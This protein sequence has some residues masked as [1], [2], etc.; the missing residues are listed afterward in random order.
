MR[1]T[2]K[3][4]GLAGLVVMLVGAGVGRKRRLIAELIRRGI[5]ERC[6]KEQCELMVPRTGSYNCY[7]VRWT[8]G[9]EELRDALK[10][11]VQAHDA[12]ATVAITPADLI[13]PTEQTP[14][15]ELQELLETA[16]K[17]LTRIKPEALL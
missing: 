1:Q 12:L 5:V 2:L 4:V 3:Q 10:T 6:G 16:L 9:N 14:Q 13:P 11:M 15:E 7:Y 17:V 8:T